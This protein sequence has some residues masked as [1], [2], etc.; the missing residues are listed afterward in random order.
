M[1]T[2]LG[3]LSLIR[4][5]PVSCVTSQRASAL[6]D[7]LDIIRLKINVLLIKCSKM[8]SEYGLQVLSLMHLLVGIIATCRT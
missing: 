1:N 8:I 2:W 6:L 5:V 4:Q 7:L 3:A